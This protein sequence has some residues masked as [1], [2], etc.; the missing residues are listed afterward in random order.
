MKKHILFIL[1]VLMTFITIT[2]CG[3]KKDDKSKKKAIEK[4]M[5]YL[6]L[7]NKESKLPDYW[8]DVIELADVTNG[9][10]ETYKVEKK[11]AEAYSKLRNDLLK[12]GITIELD[13]TYRTVS[14]QQEI[15][16]EFL[17]EYGE[18][19]TKKYVAVPGT[20]EHHT[21]LAIDVKLIK[22][23]KVIDD[24][25]EM[26]AEKEL[27]AKIHAKLADYGFILR[28]PEGKEGITGYGAEVWHFRYLDDK[29]IAKYIMDNNLTFE[30][31]LKENK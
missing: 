9:L 1:L 19:Y 18:E 17:E 8:E 28:Y 14:E 27:F 22:D 10:G 15:W 30:E 23:G 25:D 11:A 13:S 5:D 6:I 12:E 26:T 2:G 4:K 3:S 31:Y 7:V 16:D 20:S 21:G 29:E 24:N